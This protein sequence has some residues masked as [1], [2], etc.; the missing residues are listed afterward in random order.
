MCVREVEPEGSTPRQGVEE[1]RGKRAGT[2]SEKNSHSRSAHNVFMCA[3]APRE[4]IGDLA[5]AAARREQE[6]AD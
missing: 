2:H 3:C 5:M 4:C 1:A 6:K